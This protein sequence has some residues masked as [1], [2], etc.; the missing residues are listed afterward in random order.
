VIKFKESNKKQLT[1]K[2]YKSKT[3]YWINLYPRLSSKVKHSHQICLLEKICFY[4]TRNKYGFFLYSAR[5]LS[6]LVFLFSLTLIVATYP[7]CIHNDIFDYYN[8]SNES[9]CYSQINDMD[10]LYVSAHIRL[11][12]LQ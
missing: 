6:Y 7:T 5:T 10:S 8:A 11:K 12:K 1:R 4:I 2:K 3:H 9:Y